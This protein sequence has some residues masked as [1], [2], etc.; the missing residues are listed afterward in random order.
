MY[1]D[2]LECH[3]SIMRTPC[4]QDDDVEMETT[5]VVPVQTL[6]TGFNPDDNGKLVKVF[7]QEINYFNVREV[8]TDD[9]D[10]ENFDVSNCFPD[11]RSRIHLDMFLKTEGK[12]CSSQ[13]AV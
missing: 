6:L 9:I 7:T 13:T 4:H 1:V 5:S 3:A 11:D 2:S 8:M 10:Y 12:C